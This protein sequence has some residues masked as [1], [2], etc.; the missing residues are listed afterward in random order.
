M[1]NFIAHGFEQALDISLESGNLS[2]QE[3]GR[4]LM[5]FTEKYNHPQWTERM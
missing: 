2:A 5:L 3:K 1:A 4:A